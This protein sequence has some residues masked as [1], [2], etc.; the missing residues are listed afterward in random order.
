MISNANE[1]CV[2]GTGEQEV[3]ADYGEISKSGIDFLIC[4]GNSQLEE[5]SK[6]NSWQ[7]MQ[8]AFNRRAIKK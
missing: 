2:L 8:I 7:S 6:E 5:P 3:D 4:C 1:E